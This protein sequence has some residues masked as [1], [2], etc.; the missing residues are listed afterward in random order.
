MSKT[1]IGI[2]IS[3]SKFDVAVLLLN[4]KIKNRKF[5]NRVSGFAEFIEWLKKLETKDLHACMEATGN[6]GEGLAI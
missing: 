6:Y 3:K 1:V 2:D 4:N 5:N